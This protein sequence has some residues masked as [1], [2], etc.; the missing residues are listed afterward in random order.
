MG[1][2][3]GYD[4]TLGQEAL[5]SAITKFMDNLV[6]KLQNVEWSG[7]VATVSGNDV[8]INAGREVG[9]NPGDILT[10]QTLGKEIIDPQTKLVLGRTRGAVK[11]ELQVAEIDEKFSI[12]KVRSGTGFQ[13]GDLVKLK[14]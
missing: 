4:E 5:R 8:Y 7:A 13:V 11:G 10:V 14:K 3:A 9:L 2:R 1:T 12:A 6:Q